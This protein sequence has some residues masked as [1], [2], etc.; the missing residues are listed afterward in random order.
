MKDNLIFSARDDILEIRDILCIK[1]A[2]QEGYQHFNDI[3]RK[4]YDIMEEDQQLTRT[5]FATVIHQLFPE[6]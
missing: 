4:V 2:G 5:A 1:N 3:I 6:I